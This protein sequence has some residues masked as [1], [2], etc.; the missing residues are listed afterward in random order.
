MGQAFFDAGDDRRIPA[1]L[2]KHLH[3]RLAGVLPIDDRRDPSTSV[4]DDAMSGLGVAG[5]EP[6]V[7]QDQPGPL[8]VHPVESLTPRPGPGGSVMTPLSYDTPGHG[9]PSK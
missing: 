6:P 3:Q 1:Q 4:L 5:G 8:V 9:I 2:G 7:R